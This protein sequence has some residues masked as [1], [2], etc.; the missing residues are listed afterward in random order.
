MDITSKNFKVTLAWLEEKP[1]YYAKD[2]F[3]IQYLKEKDVSLKDAKYVFNMARNKKGIVKKAYKRFRK[4]IPAANL[5]C[6]R[7]KTENLVYE[8]SK[9]IALALS[10][11]Q[12]TKLKKKT[13]NKLIN[14]LNKYPTLKNDLK[15]IASYQPFYKLLKSNN[16][17]F[18]KV[19]F[20]TGKNFRQKFLNHPI[21]LKKLKKLSKSKEINRFIR[22]VLS[23]KSL[24][25][26]Q[27]SLL[28]IKNTKHLSHESNFLLAMNA[29]KHKKEKLSLVFLD[30]AY[31]K[32]YYKIDKDKSLFWKYLITKKDK[33][34]NELSKS[35]DNN[36]Y[37]IY[38]K[39]LLNIRIKNIVYDID[40]INKKT[41]FNINNQFEWIKVLDDINK[42]LN[43]AK[44]I[45]Y[46]ELFTGENTSAHL[47]FLLE[48]FYKYKID[49]Y[50]TPYKNILKKYNL[51]R[52]IQIY[53]I[54]K[55]E[56]RFIPSS[57]STATAQGI[58]QIMP[59]LSKDISKKLNEPYNI[60][61]QFIPEVNI[62]YANKHLNVL[63]RM[64]KGNILFM[65]YA[66][67]GGAGYFKSQLKKGLFKKRN[68]YEPFLSMELISYKETR[69]YGK[70]VL[71][72]YYIY[73][74][75]LNEKNLSMASILK[76]LK[77]PL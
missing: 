54:A 45:K 28:K 6:Y 29:L 12:A 16:K 57:I 25:N 56:S 53:S 2:F 61:E 66:Y 68:K 7:M 75:H 65:A 9:C 13:L 60:Y 71:A 1:K 21:P 67:N 8:N 62:R 48:R 30:N 39:E 72:N 14:K 23:D 24:H 69:E 77:N 52:Q 36:I 22:Y 10:L 74:N 20:K 41:T 51:N 35:W 70:K 19:F 55:Q 37:T 73:N 32:A 43:E 63:E 64:F 40:H 50:I 27:K 58:M 34:I 15:I 38:T 42:D 11:K 59:F 17:R 26:L 5:R 4:K 47:A 3:I 18:Y 33:Y 46:M 44:I 31:N 76:T 49:F